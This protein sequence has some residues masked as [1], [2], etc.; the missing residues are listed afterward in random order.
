MG[1]IIGLI[2]CSKKKNDDHDKKMPAQ[3]LYKGNIFKQ[4]KKFAQEK[5][6]KKEWQDWFILSGK[7]GLLEKN[8]KIGYYDCYLKD[9]PAAERRN[10]ADEILKELSSKY[11]FD[12]K[13]DKFVILGGQSYYENLK[14][15][16]NCVV[17]K[18][19]SGGIY[20]DNNCKTEFK[21]GGK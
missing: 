20:L 5:C 16:L 9:K 13:R 4:S 12:L 2:A 1:K 21:N 10:W 7:Y 18:C 8:E 6:A 15:H 3:E 17:F 19:S 14:K 11:K